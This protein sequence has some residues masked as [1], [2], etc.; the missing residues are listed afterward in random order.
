MNH[1]DIIKALLFMN[2]N[3]LA[4]DVTLSHVGKT[5]RCLYIREKENSCHDSSEIYI[6]IFAAATNSTL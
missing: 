6:T 5:Y 1:D 2:S 3:A 4:M